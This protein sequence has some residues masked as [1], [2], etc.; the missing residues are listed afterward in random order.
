[1]VAAMPTVRPHPLLRYEAY[2]RYLWRLLMLEFAEQS[3]PTNAPRL[4]SAATTIKGLKL[5][6]AVPPLSTRHTTR[7]HR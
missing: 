5:V 4:L 6:L 7:T 3:T 2:F 1:M